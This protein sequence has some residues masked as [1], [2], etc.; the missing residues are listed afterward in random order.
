MRYDYV[1]VG[2]GLA[3]G[4]A[5]EGIRTHDAKGSI[6]MLS[7]EN[8]P[9]YHRP[10]LSKDL[11]FGKSTLESLPFK[12]ESFYR[13]HG[14]E[15]AL[16]REAVE[17]DL[18]KKEVWDDHGASY[19]YERLLLATGGLPRRLNVP[20]AEH[21]TVH[22]YRTLEDYMFLQER[23]ARLRHVLV[24]GAGFIG[25]EMAAAL[26]HV[27]KEV[28][29]LY[30]EPYPLKRVLPRDLGLFVAEYYRQ[31]GVETVSEETVARFED[32]DGEIAAHTTG[33]NLVTTQL[34]LAGVGLTPS[35][36]LA[37]AAGLLV[38]GGIEVDEYGRTSDPRVYAAGDV[39]E[40]PCLPLDRRM[41]I[42]HWDHALQHGKAVGA[43]MAGAN[44]PYTH[45]PF[46]YSDL[47]DLG[48]EAVGEVDGQLDTHAVWKQE[49]REG[50]VYYMRDDTVRGVL[51]W[52]VWNAVDWAR[53]LI[54]QAKP[55]THR[56]L[57]AAVP[58]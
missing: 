18:A 34:V 23:L 44:R 30:P 50:V 35:S 26:L 32:R 27:G 25:M 16:R 3:A 58:A 51:L 9:P 21:E 38:G 6:L 2:G 20:G 57:E 1:I 13:D 10:P 42:E 33:G 39:A 45:L 36:D 7:G 47:F 29:L 4:S 53:G 54:R 41:R 5:I 40:F 22:Y 56:E 12:P 49:H 46:F 11:W 37:E 48:W 19:G 17:L 24:V 43:N 8:H 28:T 15:L 52:N 14:V 55:M 31:K